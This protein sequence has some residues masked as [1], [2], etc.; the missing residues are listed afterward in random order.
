MPEDAE[1]DGRIPLAVVRQSFATRSTRSADVADDFRWGE[2]MFELRRDR[3]GDFGDFGDHGL[4]MLLRADVGLS[5]A[6]EGMNFGVL[7]TVAGGDPCQC[8]ETP[9]SAQW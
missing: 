5:V 8:I 9:T 4:P 7:R 1:V 2:I 3:P 6:G